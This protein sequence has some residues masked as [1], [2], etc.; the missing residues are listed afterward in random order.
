MPVLLFAEGASRPCCMLQ[1]EN[2]DAM[3]EDTLHT[4]VEHLAAEKG[5]EANA[6]MQYPQLIA[7]RLCILGYRVGVVYNFECFKLQG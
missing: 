2:Y 5:I 1:V 4:V 6:L 7:H 3:F